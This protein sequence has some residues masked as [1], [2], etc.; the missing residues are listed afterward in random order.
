MKTALIAVLTLTAPAANAIDCPTTDITRTYHQ[1]DVSPDSF[2]VLLGRFEF[3]PSSMPDSEVDVPLDPAP[4]P[5]RFIGTALTVDGFTRDAT[6]PV[7]LQPVCAANWCGQMAADSA[8]V[9]VF[10]R[11]TD[12]GYTVALHPCGGAVFSDDATTIAIVTACF[13]GKVCNSLDE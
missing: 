6:G 9:I 7:V 2:V 12:G 13:Q 5:A 11:V 8:R 4:V 10:A 3:D 1:S